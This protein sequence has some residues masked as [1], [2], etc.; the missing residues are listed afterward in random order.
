[1]IETTLAERLGKQI[2]E[3]EEKRQ[4]LVEAANMQISE[5]NGRIAALTEL[6]AELKESPEEGRDEEKDED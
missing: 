5:M 6:L 3:L 4:Q 1:M 2:A